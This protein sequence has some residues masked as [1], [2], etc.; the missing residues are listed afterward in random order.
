VIRNIDI[1]SVYDSQSGGRWQALGSDRWS[2][3]RSAPPRVP[4]REHGPFQPWS[5]R[6]LSL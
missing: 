6:P 3:D 4:Y 1:T 5:C 2:G